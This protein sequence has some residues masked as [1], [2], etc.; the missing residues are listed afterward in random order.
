MD[1]KSH[2]KPQ[3]SGHGWNLPPKPLFQRLASR[4]APGT[5][6]PRSLCQGD[7]AKLELLADECEDEKTRSHAL[8]IVQEY[9]NRFTRLKAKFRLISLK[10]KRTNTTY[11]SQRAE[12][13]KGSSTT[14]S[15]EIDP[16]SSSDVTKSLQNTLEI[17]RQELD[18]SVMSTHLLALISSLKRADIID[19]ILLTGALIFFGL[20]CLYILKKRILDKGVSIISTLISPLSR[21]DSSRENS[22]DK[23]NPIYNRDLVLKTV[24]TTTAAIAT[25]TAIARAPN[26]IPSPDIH[27]PPTAPSSLK[28]S[29]SQDDLLHE[30]L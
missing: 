2:K 12:L 10:L 14:S 25:A 7:C 24:I 11:Q 8:K 1:Q 5:T 23:T 3:L 20:V 16:S 15:S 6:G 28:I 30:E 19:R 26:P 18:R 17:M 21:M 29:S 22:I 13:L 27:L 9:S 4:G